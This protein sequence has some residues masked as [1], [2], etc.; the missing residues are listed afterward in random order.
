M[1]ELEEIN[2]LL[3][4]RDKLKYDAI[5]QLSDQLVGLSTRLQEIDHT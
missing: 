1:E 2:Q 3:R 4:N 5:S